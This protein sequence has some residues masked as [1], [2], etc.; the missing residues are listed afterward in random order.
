MLKDYHLSGEAGTDGGDT[1]NTVWKAQTFVPLS[2]YTTTSIALRVFRAVGTGGTITVSLR[3]TSDGLPTGADLASGTI[4]ISA[5]DTSTPGQFHTATLSA[6]VA[7]TAGTR[8]AIVYRRDGS[9]GNVYFRVSTATV[10]AF[11]QYCSSS[12]S[13]GTWALP[14]SPDTKDVVFK[15][16][17]SSGYTPQLLYTAGT[18]SGGNNAWSVTDDGETLTLLDSFSLGAGGNITA[19]TYEKASDKLYVADNGAVY[20][21]TAS[22]MTL[23][24]SWGSSGI[25]T[26]GALINDLAVDS[27]NF[28]AVAHNLAGGGRFS[29]YGSDGV[30]D[31]TSAVFS[32]GNGYRVAFDAAG[33][34]AGGV[35]A[36]G[37]TSKV[38]AL[39]SRTN[40]TL[41]ATYLQ[42]P[43]VA[44]FHCDG[45]AANPSSAGY[46]WYANG[47]STT[48]SLSYSN[49]TP[50]D[51]S[52][53]FTGT[54]RDVVLLSGSELV[55]ITSTQALRGYNPV[56]G[57]AHASADYTPIVGASLSA[58][59]LAKLSKNDS[60]EFYACGDTGIIAVGNY[61]AS[62]RSTLTITASALVGIGWAGDYDS[63]IT[64]TS[65][66]TSSTSGA[67]TYDVWRRFLTE[68]MPG[69][70]ATL[71]SLT[72]TDGSLTLTGLTANSLIYT[73]AGGV[74]TSLGAA[75]N[76]QIPIGSTGAA[77]VL[78]TITGTANQITS[79]PGAGSI[80]LSLPQNIHTAAT[81]TFAD[82]TLSTPVNIYALNH[83]SFT[84]FV[85]NEHIDHSAVSILA[86]TGMS[87]GGD[88][89]ASRTLTCTITQY[90]DALA[91][92]AIS[93]TVTGLGYDSGT[94]VLSLTV[95]YV[96]P[97]TTQ[98]TNW[99]TAYG[100]GNH[101]SAGYLTSPVA[102]AD[103][104][105]GQTTAQAAIDALTAVAAATN[106]HVL[107]KDTVSGNAIW[108]AATGG[109]DAFTV[110]VDAAATADYLGATAAVGALRTSTG[111]TKTDGGDFITLTTNDS[112]IA[113]DS[114][115]GYSANRH[116]DHTT[117]TLTAGTGMSGGGD[118]S[119]N[120]TFNCLGLLGDGTAGRVLR[121]VYLTVQNGTNAATLKCQV[122]NIW[123]GDPVG[124]TDNIAKGAT[125]GV[126]NLEADG[127][128][129]YWLDTGI[130]GDSI[131]A[132]GN[133]TNNTSGTTILTTVIKKASPAGI[134]FTARNPAT[135]TAYDL[136]T[137]VDS[138]NFTIQII[139]FTSA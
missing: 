42:G 61:S 1:T 138:G 87:G 2:S 23:D 19:M 62:A 135:G 13:G 43:G 134:E 120:R 139:Y 100:W 103:G 86:G 38:A 133:L 72:L 16:Y 50:D 10:F 132:W 119:A 21:Y 76:G 112:Q 11:G 104:G 118:I 29:L 5:L 121:N 27:S 113:H 52:K 96:I 115:S 41:L 39:I 88:I 24:T 22:T 99:G 82:L 81:P 91:R 98:E 32:G 63:P 40:G 4:A 117:V 71:G 14:G 45:I 49:S 92:A 106:E 110:K 28:L 80:T 55:F 58:G 97:T 130:T 95:G 70:D 137:L 48:V 56:D 125:T 93:E 102:I 66:G 6:G 78:A 44:G 122:I 116:I 15:V 37:S 111:I 67:L 129:V 123:N 101:A 89:S 33:N 46:V 59:T 31:W 30:L 79:T 128:S 20:R 105:T 34:M 108:K 85:A 64:G 83:D 7:L 35:Q 74:L 127:T 109:A 73:P 84:G 124:S 126:F 77:P 3:A 12:D 25:A 18:A 90:T 60:L 114:L 107:T 26:V 57:L 54:P 131:V 75:T 9:D 47:Y 136:T 69:Y 8:Y 65:T 68:Y 17:D 94:G 51:W 53:S 36:A